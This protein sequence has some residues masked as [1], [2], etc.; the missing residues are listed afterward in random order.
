MAWLGAEWR[1]RASVTVDNSS[2]S[3]GAQD[4]TITLPT[5]WAR[6]YAHVNQTDARDVRITLADGMTLATY[7]LES[8]SVSGDTGALTVEL[9]NVQLTAGKMHHL[10][11]YWGHDTASDA[12][13]S[14][15][16]SSPRTGYVSLMQ[17]EPALAVRVTHPRYGDTA[18]QAKVAKAVNTATYVWFDFGPLL[19]RYTEPTSG[20][21]E[22]EEID[23]IDGVSVLTPSGTDAPTMYSVSNCRIVDGRYVG[24]WLEAGANPGEYTVVARVVTTAQPPRTLEGRASLGA[25]NLLE[26]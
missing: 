2:G 21:L 18:P 3:T 19:A 17:P 11:L 26:T 9:A 6:F 23:Y 8:F 20:H 10:W 7:D 12:Q 16:P 25:Q 15:A 13:S 1:Y 14:V 22:Y 24:V 5:A 4:V